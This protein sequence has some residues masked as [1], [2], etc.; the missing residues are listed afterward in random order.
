MQRERLT[1]PAMGSAENL[2]KF[3]NVTYLSALTVAVVLWDDVTDKLEDDPAFLTALRVK[4]RWIQSP[5][6]C[7]GS[8]IIAMITRRTCK[9]NWKLRCVLL[10]LLLGKRQRQ[11][12]QVRASLRACCYQ[13]PATHPRCLGRHQRLP[14]GTPCLRAAR[15]LYP[16]VASPFDLCR[17]GKAAGFALS[18]HRS[19]DDDLSGQGFAQLLLRGSSWGCYEHQCFADH[20]ADSL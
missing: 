9:I 16:E 2:Q 13:K 14:T 10:R 3:H 17:D 20:A 11:P 6:S 7:E 5:D 19:F 1:S 12:T 8:W 15:I 18:C 4:R